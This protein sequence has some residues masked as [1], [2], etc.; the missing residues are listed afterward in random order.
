M[1]RVNSRICRH[2]WKRKDRGRRTTCTARKPKRRS[3]RARIPGERILRWSERY[4]RGIQMRRHESCE[5]SD[6]GWR[7]FRRANGHGDESRARELV[8]ARATSSSVEPL[9]PMSVKIASSRGSLI[10]SKRPIRVIRTPACRQVDSS[11]PHRTQKRTQER[12]RWGRDR[13]T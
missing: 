10:K 7:A 8:E 13:T 6:A 2:R 3:R 5:S 11:P 12:L 4:P 9:R 1:I